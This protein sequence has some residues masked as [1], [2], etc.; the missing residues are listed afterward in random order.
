MFNKKR[1]KLLEARVALL[2]QRAEVT[3]FKEKS[4]GKVYCYRSI[5]AWYRE[6]K[7]VLRLYYPLS[8][9]AW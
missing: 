3:D 5:Q 4:N 6:F 9:R 1:I 2:E 8:F 7:T